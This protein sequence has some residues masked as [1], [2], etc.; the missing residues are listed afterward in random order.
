MRKNAHGAGR[1]VGCRHPPPKP[2]F[3]TSLALA[4]TGHLLQQLA[5][6]VEHDDLM[7]GLLPVA[8]VQRDVDVPVGV[9]RHPSV[10]MAFCVN[11]PCVADPAVGK[12]VGDDATGLDTEGDRFSDRGGW[13][14]GAWH[15]RRRHRRC[16]HPGKTSMP[17]LGRKMLSTMR[18]RLPSGSSR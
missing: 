13:C 12:V 6:A 11:Q 4:G 8:V 3:V 7:L 15:Y 14:A 1:H 9:E 16:G 17:P 2:R 10:Q 5:G 18:V